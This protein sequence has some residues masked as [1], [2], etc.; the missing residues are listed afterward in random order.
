MSL[1]KTTAIAKLAIVVSEQYVG[2]TSAEGG[3]ITLASD[4]VLTKTVDITRLQVLLCALK[5]TPQIERFGV[6]FDLISVDTSLSIRK[7][8]FAR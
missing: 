2:E 1:P 5:K 8:V 7:R 6:F 4:D 3:R